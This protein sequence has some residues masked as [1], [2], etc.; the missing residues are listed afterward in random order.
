[1]NYKQNIQL[2]AAGLALAISLFISAAHAQN[3]VTNP[4]FEFGAFVDR[5]DG[6]QILPNGSTAIT[7]WTVINDQLAWGV[8]PNSAPAVSPITPFDGRFFLDL[9]GDGLFNPPYG[10]VM[11]AV[12]TVVGQVYHFTMNLGTQ[13]DATSPFTHG[14][15]SVQASAGSISSVFTFDPSATSGTQWGEFGFDFTATSTSTNLSI[16]G[17]NTAGGAFIGLD[18]VSLT[19]VRPSAVPENGSSIFLLA[20]GLAGV[21]AVRRPALS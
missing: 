17:T 19:A 4:S 10:G 18:L 3:L 14:P 16:I 21:V 13:Q 6:Y 7:G 2:P 8:F 20:L 12:A 9:Q 11:Q 5:G 1:M 15:V